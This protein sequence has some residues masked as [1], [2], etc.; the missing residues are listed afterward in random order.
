M[1]SSSSDVSDRAA[2]AA[3]AAPTGSLGSLSNPELA[4]LP[5]AELVVRLYNSRRGSEFA[6][7]AFVLAER[8]RRLA[9]AEAQIRRADEREAR[10][11]QAEVRACERRST[12]PG[13]LLPADVRGA[14][15]TV[16]SVGHQLE[17]VQAHLVGTHASR[18]S[19]VEVA[20]LDCTPSAVEAAAGVLAMLAEAAADL[21]RP[22]PLRTTAADALILAPAPQRGELAFANT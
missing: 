14:D 21:P 4:S 20:L 11:L 6:D 9:E 15:L 7:A 16:A 5:A 2:A 12:E 8:E 19:E 17:G 18:A 10:R 3:V 13:E 1:G 22:S